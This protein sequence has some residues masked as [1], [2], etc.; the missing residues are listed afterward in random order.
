MEA[1][2]QIRM[3]TLVPTTS[4]LHYLS[5]DEARRSTW[6]R[7][8]QA[9]GNLLVRWGEPAKGLAEIASEVAGRLDP[10]LDLAKGPPA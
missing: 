10:H 7:L 2:E 3:V 4:V 9:T 1:G 5:E 6:T 8:N